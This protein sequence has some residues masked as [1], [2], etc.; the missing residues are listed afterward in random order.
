MLQKS[1]GEIAAQP[2]VEQELRTRQDI[3]DVDA[4]W[5][6]E[7]FARSKFTSEMAEGLIAGGLTVEAAGL[8]LQEELRL[9]AANR[10]T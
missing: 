6:L 7:G 5:A 2:G 9:L 1:S 4:V 10:G 3:A 8:R